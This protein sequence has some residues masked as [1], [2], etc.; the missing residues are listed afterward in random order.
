MGVRHNLEAMRDSGAGARRLVAVGG[1]TAQRLWTQIVSDVT[2]L[3][4]DLPTLTVGASYGDARLAADALG[5]DTTTWN[6]VAERL[7][8]D[9][10]FRETYERLYRVYVDGHRTLSPAMHTLGDIDN[11]GRSRWPGHQA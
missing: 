11:D 9:E 7:T 1:G 2:A 6:P 3:P 8:P 10:E 4:Q 5:V